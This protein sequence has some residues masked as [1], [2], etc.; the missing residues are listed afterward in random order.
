MREESR[1]GRR[2]RGNRALVYGYARHRCR[3]PRDLRSLFADATMAI[4]GSGRSAWRRGGS[5][6]VTRG[7]HWYDG[8]PRTRHITTNLV[9]ALGP[10][11]DRAMR[12]ARWSCTR[13]S[14]TSPPGDPRR[15]LRR[16]VR[17]GRGRMALRPARV[18]LRPPG[19]PLEALHQAGPRFC[20]VRGPLRLEATST[21]LRCCPRHRPPAWASPGMS[22]RSPGSSS[23][24]PARGRVRR[25]RRA[26]CRSRSSR[27]GADRSTLRGRGARTA[28]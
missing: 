27:C 22:T 25:V 15:A 16:R 12:R 17:A 8:T 1:S 9:V 10:D 6:L 20:W 26:R 13:R 5:R 11:G 2:P 28:S 4:A 3:R 23:T 7:L 18:D 21:T 19:R 24:L 14:P